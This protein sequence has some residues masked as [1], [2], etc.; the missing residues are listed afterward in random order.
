MRLWWAHDS[1]FGLV[2]CSMLI[3]EADNDEV[4]LECSGGLGTWFRDVLPPR[5]DMINDDDAD[6]DAGIINDGLFRRALLVKGQVVANTIPS[7][8]HEVT[9]RKTSE[10]W[11]GSEV[12]G[13]ALFCLSGTRATASWDG[14]CTFLS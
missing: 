5:H 10:C 9:K 11:Q 14:D 13:R 1:C 4:R 3:V 6:D 2:G 7:T 12:S 8:W